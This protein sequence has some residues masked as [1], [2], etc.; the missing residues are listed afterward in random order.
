MGKYG[1]SLI[2]LGVLALVSNVAWYIYEFIRIK[3]HFLYRLQDAYWAISLM[4]T[5]TGVGLIV[6][7]GFCVALARELKKE[8]AAKIE[9][10]EREK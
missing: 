1:K 3:Q 10:N 5:Y 9:N 6:A 2:L 8:A 7:G 4:P